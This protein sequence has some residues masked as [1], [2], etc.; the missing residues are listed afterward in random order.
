MERYESSSFQEW[1]RLCGTNEACLETV[2]KIR[3]P[4]GF[5]CPLFGHDRTSILTRPRIRPCYGC[6]FHA[7]T[8]VGTLFESTRLPLSKWFAAI[9]P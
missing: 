6:M 4:A 2:A 7:S 8:L 5:L 1:V 3:W 9:Y